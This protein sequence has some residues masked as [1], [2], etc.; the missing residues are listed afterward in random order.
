MT[1]FHLGNTYTIINFDAFTCESEI[2]IIESSPFSKVLTKFLNKLE[3][4]QNSLLDLLPPLSV[5]SL[6]NLYKILLVYEV[7]DIRNIN[8]L[9]ATFMNHKTTFYELTEQFYDYWRKIERFGLIRAS[10]YANEDN[11]KQEL[12]KKSDLFNEKVLSLYRTI[13]QKLLG[14]HYNVYRQLPAGVNAN[15]LYVNHEF[16]TKKELATLQKTAFITGILLRPPFIIYSKKNTREGYFEETF[17]N[18]LPHLNINRLHYVAFPLKVGNLLAYIY[19]H[20]DFLHHGVALTNL[21]EIAKHEEF[22]GKTPDLVYYYGINEREYDATYYHDK[23]NNIYFGYVSR[24]DKNDY[25]GYLKKMILTLHNVKMIDQ[26]NLPIHGAMV[27]LVLRDNSV[28]NIAI[29][30]DSGAGKSEVLEAL[31]TL[32][33]NYI[34]KI[35]VIFDDMGTFI[36]NNGEIKAIGTEIGAFVR[37]DDLESGYAYQEMERAIFL[38]PHQKNARVIIPLSMYSYIKTPHH[39]DMVLYA[40]NYENKEGL[41]LFVSKEEALPVFKEGKRFAKGTT[42]EIGLVSSY[43]ANPFGPYQKQD[44]TNV[45]LASYFENLFK[46][47]VI[48]GEIYTKLGLIGQ[49]TSG[50]QEAV[51]ALLTHLLN[52]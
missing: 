32:G 36:E 49:E 13:T 6:L 8:P 45:L 47:K 23:V 27:S 18:P 35:K 7:E 9:L 25:F 30:G 10:R 1:N 24:D 28:K 22:Y 41:K 14:H 19:I 31:R 17:D 51:K 5:T 38:N 26:G 40:N 50:P 21:F 48:V 37:L 20:R 44:Q 39:L 43:F 34:K 33:S 46:H 2:N 42:S 3:E 12:I 15:I 52:L 4:E 29:I 16:S 11:K